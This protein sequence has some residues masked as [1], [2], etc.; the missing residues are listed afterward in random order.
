MPTRFGSPLYQEHQPNFDSSAVAILRTAGALIF[1]LFDLMNSSWQY[2]ILSIGKTTT[3]EFSVA[4][5]GSRTTNPHNSSRTPGGSSCGSAAAVADFHVPL[6][7]GVQTRGSI[8]RPASYTGVFALKP[9]YNAISPEGQKTFSVTFDTVGF[10]ARSVKDLQLVSGIFALKD[11]ESP[12]NI[13]LNEATVALIKTPMWSR[14]GPGTVSCMQKAAAILKTNGVSV[15]EVSFPLECDDAPSLEQLQEAIIS[16]ES[17]VAFLREYR[18]DKKMLG[19]DIC[20]IVENSANYTNK[21]R[22]EAFD[23]YCSFRPMIDKLAGGYSAIITPSVIDEAPL[24]L[25]DMG[26]PDFNTL[27]T[28][29]SSPSDIIQFY[30]T[31]IR[32]Y[33]SP[34]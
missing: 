7:L 15:E 5:T 19:P 21:D 26:S 22:M 27:W 28:V 11:D 2:L 25:D 31:F 18:M 3:T 4:N 10:F 1:G 16:S 13:P 12:R 30:L 32:D 29:S 17:R 9:T 24:G 23:K 34:L 20:R 8:I 33:M 14:A 6:S